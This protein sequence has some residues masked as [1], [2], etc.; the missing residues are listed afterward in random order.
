MFHPVHADAANRSGPPLSVGH[1][2]REKTLVVSGAWDFPPTVHLEINNAPYHAQGSWQTMA[3]FTGAGWDHLVFA[4]R[5]I[6]A[7]VSGFK[8]GEAPS[9]VLAAS[10]AIT[11]TFVD[12]PC[13]AEGDGPGAGVATDE[14]GPA[15]LIQVGGTFSGV[16][17]V[18]FSGDGQGW[19]VAHSFTGPGVRDVRCLAAYMR[20]RRTGSKRTA[21]G[22]A[23]EC[24]I[25]VVA[26]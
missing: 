13:A 11:P 22:A 5:W 12:I 7:T 1:L 10:S 2:G 17:H 14:L 26:A 20:V 19:A 25:V 21:P 15:K 18:E 24:P 8:R 16:I 9:V 6:R 4:A 23:P 3:W